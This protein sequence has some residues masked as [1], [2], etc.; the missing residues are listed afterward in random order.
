MLHAE[1]QGTRSRDDLAVEALAGA[2]LV[3]AADDWRDIC[4][5]KH[6]PHKEGFRRAVASDR[7]ALVS[8]RRFFRSRWCVS[9]CNGNPETPK[10][11]LAQLEEEYGRS[12]IKKQIDGCP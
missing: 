10:R 1:Q 2:V 11:V 5:H 3:R 12:L 4:R 6:D 8:L 7:R 9:L